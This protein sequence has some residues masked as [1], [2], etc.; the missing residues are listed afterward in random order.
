MHFWKTM[1]LGRLLMFGLLVGVAGVLVS[2][3]PAAAADYS[4]NNMMDDGVF[5]NVGAMTVGSPS[6]TVNQLQSQIQAFF[7]GQPVAI[8]G[9]RTATLSGGSNCLKN[10]NDVE[11]T[12]NGTSWSYGGSVPAARII[13]ETAIQWGLNPEVIISTIEKEESLVS[14]T[15]CDGWRYA[16]AMG[17]GCP[18]SGGCNPKYAGLTR[19][20]LWGSW[21]LKFGEQRSYGNTAWDGDDSLTYGGYMTQGTRKRCD[22]CTAFFFDGNATITN[23]SGG[24][25]ITVHMDNGTTAALYSYTPHYNQSFPGIFEGWFGSVRVPTFGWSFVGQY[26]YTDQNKTTG[27]GTVGMLPFT[28]VYVGVVALNTGNT[29]WTNSGNNPV[30]LGTWGPTDRTSAFCDSWSLGCT[31]PAEM[32]EASVAPGQMAHF[33]FYMK[34]PLNPGTYVEHFNLLAEWA[35]WMP[36]TGQNFTMQVVPATYSWESLGVF[37]Y[38]DQTMTA[39]RGTTGL[40]PGDR[41]YVG[42]AAKN[43]GNMVWT[44]TGDS[45]AQVVTTGPQNRGSTFRD[46]TWLSPSFAADMITPSVAPGQTG[47]FGF[48]MRAAALGAFTEHFSLVT[49]NGI[50]FNDPGV[51]YYMTVEPP[52]YAWQLIGQ[53]AYSDQTMTSGRA[54]TGLA[55]GSK[56]FIGFAAKNTGNLTWVNNGVSAVSVATTTPFDRGSVFYDTTW[57]SANRQAALTQASVAPGQIGNFGFW[58]KAPSTPGAYIEHFSL[59]AGSEAVGNQAVLNDPGLNF[60][61]TVQ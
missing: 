7:N 28:K 60:Y 48:W 46:S 9:A 40:L 19:Q 5:E 10:Y 33:E 45:R 53:Y 49:A 14:G 1:G 59:V 58:M 57:I 18:D 42:F 24:S 15:A 52:T 21:Q 13:A 20:V 26:V 43:T 29:T 56:V 36:D 50:W 35:A 27:S 16:S 3:K 30:R 38:T 11:A 47:V 55:P 37:A 39:G 32:Q 17:Y 44:N 23:G 54:T 22:S 6:P 34:A 31:R 2:A 4:N 41:V 8:T 61:L 25:P 12:F 51:G